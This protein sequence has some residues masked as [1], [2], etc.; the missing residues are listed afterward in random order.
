[1][2]IRHSEKYKDSVVNETT[3]G[4]FFIEKKCPTCHQDVT[5]RA[6]SVDDAKRII[7]KK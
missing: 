4:R 7:D 6:D 5:L 1:M 2:I 3:D